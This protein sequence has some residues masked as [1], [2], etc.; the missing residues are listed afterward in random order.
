MTISLV[1][2]ELKIQYVGRVKSVN[3]SIITY[4][5]IIVDAIS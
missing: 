2:D 4:P 3:Y 5:F 1:G